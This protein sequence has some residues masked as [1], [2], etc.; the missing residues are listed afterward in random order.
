[1]LLLLFNPFYIL[2][3]YILFVHYQKHT[4][5]K[6]LAN[7]VH[8]YFVWRSKA[9]THQ[10]QIDSP[11]AAFPAIVFN[12][13]G[14][15]KLL[16]G[17]DTPSEYV[18]VPRVFLSGQ[19][20]R[21]YTILIDPPIEQIGIVFRPTALHRLYG[22]N[23]YEFTN[24]RLQLEDVLPHQFKFLADELTTVASDDMRIGLIEKTLLKHVREAG[25][26]YDGVDHAAN[27]IIDRIGDC[28]ISDL[29]GESFM[30]R[31]KF[32]RHF[33]RRVGLSPK[34]FARIRRYGYLCSRMAG[35]RDVKWTDLLYGAGYYDQSHFIKDFK[36][37][38]G[39]VPEKYLQNNQELAHLLK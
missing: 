34:Y 24:G 29:I 33:F 13:G 37:F 32:E 23:M 14:S 25:D 2:W 9:L 6:L 31:R 5:S 4:P 36:E 8:C 7:F 16:S 28:T 35:K 39:M 11:P 15:S 27:V 22:L 30:S 12:F 38:S 26:N 17:N 18:E 20:I 1:M 3:R 21:N 10:L 19:S